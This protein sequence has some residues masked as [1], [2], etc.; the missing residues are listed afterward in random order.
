VAELSRTAKERSVQGE[1]IRV[2]PEY[3]VNLSKTDSLVS[4]YIG[5]LDLS[6][7][8]GNR[9]FLHGCKLTI[10]AQ[11]DKWVLKGVE[12]EHG[13]ASI[14]S[15]MSTDESSMFYE[16]AVTILS[17]CESPDSPMVRIAFERTRPNP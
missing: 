16:D 3:S 17:F 1:H 6:L 13:D 8:V 15:F 12:Q 4:P 11:Q 7:S 9:K 2:A 5:T 14:L 10:A